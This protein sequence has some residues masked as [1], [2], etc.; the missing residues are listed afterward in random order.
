MSIH[1][2]LTNHFLI[3][4]PQLADPHFSHTVTYVCGHTEEGAMGIVINRP[5]GMN[6]GEIF[7]HMNINTTDPQIRQQA[8]FVGG[9]LEPE[10]GFV[11]HQACRSWKNTLLI[12]DEISLTTSSDILQDI[13]EG[14]GPSHSLV[15][16]G[17]AG[18]GAGQLEQ[19][20]GE[21]SWLSAPA[22]SNVIFDLPV[23]A[24]W[25]AAATLLGVDLNKLSDEV[26]HA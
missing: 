20:M 18:W 8:V 15:A 10:H 16:L 13:A 7:Q 19:E 4:M 23:E 26:G 22:A 1:P 25:Q 5:L 9:P 6:L 24:R 2:N 17:Y 14:E 21:N 3:A 11:L 12:S